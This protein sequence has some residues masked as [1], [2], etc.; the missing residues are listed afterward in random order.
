MEDPGAVGNLLGRRRECEEIDRLLSRTR[1]GQSGVLVVSGEPGV[2]KSALLG[3]AIASA[4]GFQLAR[5]S[6]VESEMELPYA[7]LQQLCVPML[8][9]RDR[10]PSP[11]RGALEVAFGLTSGVAPSRFLVGLAVLTL[12]SEAA[13][14][15]PVICV[16]DD[17]QWLDR[18][19]V[20]ALAFV[21]R[22]L[23]AESVIVLLGTRALD[24]VLSGLPEL[25][26]RGLGI[27][28][29]RELL[30][31]VVYGPLDERVRDQLVA[32][33]RGN[34]LALLELPRG[35]T[36]AQLAGGF[37]LPA[38]ASLSG[39]IEE[40]NG[41][42]RCRLIL[43]VSCCLQ[44]QSRSA[45]QT[46]CSRPPIGWVSGPVRRNRPSRRGCSKRECG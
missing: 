11:Q 38:M 25:V 1:G 39:Q 18:A 46:F 40:R 12:L 16:V 23:L 26:V 32:E 45:I 10:L 19:S 41:T 35:L 24:K 17:T 30:G 27:T 31:Q 5:A 29:S 3:Y 44:L 14:T 6:G 4:S 42:T 36:P 15:E 7:A 37:G 34:P 43:S 8:D 28:A 33:T 20:D 2:G 13:K 9:R 22:R 21:A